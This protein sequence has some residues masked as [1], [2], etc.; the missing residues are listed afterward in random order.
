M[1]R[2]TTDI[3][4][5][6]HI[7]QMLDASEIAQLE[8]FLNLLPPSDTAYTINRI[9][10][11]HRKRLLTVIRPELAAQLIE[12]LADTQAADLIDEL[13]PQGAA[14]IVDK[15]DSDDQADILVELPDADAEAILEHMDPVEARDARRLARYEP[16]T[17]GG[18]MI[19]EYLS[20]QNNRQ[21]ADVLQDLCDN[22]KAYGDYDVQYVYVTDEGGTLL[23][24]I[25]I[26]D[27]V[28]SRGDARLDSIMVPDM[29][30][31]SAHD[32]TKQLEDVFDRY[33][34]NALPVVD[35]TE[36]LVGV[37]RR[38]AVQEAHSEQSDRD[39]L[40]IS[41]LIAGEE[42]RTMPLGPRA[43]RRLAYL[44]PNILLMVVSISVIAAFERTVLKEVI[45]LAIFLPLVAGV[46][47]G[48]AN[49]A[50]A[51]SIR[52]MSLGLTKPADLGR[53]F[54][55]ELKVG[56]I[57]GVVLGVAVFL[58]ALAM[59]GNVNIALVV[60]GAIPLTIVVSVV[61]GGTGPLILRRINVDPAMACA[62]IVSTLIDF[63]GFF[64]VLGLAWLALDALK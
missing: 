19:S 16:N 30:R 14:A 10:P 34:F 11:E 60:G 1:T 26:R 51:V 3:A 27:I 44:L 15:M 59:R 29:V 18:V 38:D 43:V 40:R 2:R 31:V 48:A 25:Q 61:L 53:V 54:A 47:G 12:H 58:V 50:L 42:L 9:A 52:E 24:L 20:Y 17:A 64:L 49:Q 22:A 57:N 13:T 6:E 62:P 32:S 4:V 46:A 37:V 28:L 45:A 36:R 21:I 7:E 23:G 5:W 56:L 39:L 33:S 41:G 63:V 35:N 55:Q 8:T